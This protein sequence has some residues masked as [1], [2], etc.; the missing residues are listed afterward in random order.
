[1]FAPI[2]N[3]QSPFQIPFSGFIWYLKQNLHPRSYSDRATGGALKALSSNMSEGQAQLAM[4]AN[5]ERQDRDA[6]AIQW[7][8]H[9]RTEHDEMESFVLAIPG[10]FTSKGALRYGEM[11]LK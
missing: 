5:D 7:L 10:T 3:P 9:N 6:K 8:I 2:L 1:M 4:E 11:F